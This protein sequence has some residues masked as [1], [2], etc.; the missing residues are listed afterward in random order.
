VSRFVTAHTFVRSAHLGSGARQSGFLG[1]CLLIQ[2]YFCA[3]YDH[4]KADLSKGYQQPKR[5]LAVTRHFSEK[6]ALKLGKKMP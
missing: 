1:I 4:R 2:R 5:K 6:V 3:V